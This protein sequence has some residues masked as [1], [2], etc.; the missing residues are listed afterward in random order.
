MEAAGVVAAV[1]AAALNVATAAEA[2][3]ASFAVGWDGTA[4]GWAEVEAAGVV[5]ATGAVVKAGERAEVGVAAGRG[6][7]VVAG[8]G[9][10]DGLGVGAGAGAGAGVGIL[11]A[12]GGRS[13]AYGSRDEL[14]AAAGRDAGCPNAGGMEADGSGFD[15]RAALRAAMY[16]ASKSLTASTI[17]D[18]S[19][20]ESLS[21]G[22]ILGN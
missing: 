5:G 15:G 17:R 3:V 21:K 9:T 12:A 8:A 20:S 7:D 10:G 14:G 6:A 11:G 19:S 4:I 22:G 2:V 16:C 1:L 13:T 18:H